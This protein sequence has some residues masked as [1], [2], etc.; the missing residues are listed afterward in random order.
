[1][2]AEENVEDFGLEPL[3]EGVFHGRKLLRGPRGG[4]QNGRDKDED[5]N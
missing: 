1:V 5:V 2:E 4:D 3:A